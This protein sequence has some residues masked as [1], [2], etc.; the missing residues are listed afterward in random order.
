M[1]IKIGISLHPDNIFG[2]CKNL[3]LSTFQGEHFLQAVIEQFC[4]IIGTQDLR[5]SKPMNFN[6]KN[7]FFEEKGPK[8]AEIV[9]NQ[10][11]AQNM[12]YNGL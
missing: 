3:K 10:D 4:Q 7:A 2:V 6:P 11:R 1:L 12:S 9:H 5:F 8:M